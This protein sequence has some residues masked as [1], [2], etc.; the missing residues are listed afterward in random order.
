MRKQYP[1][2][3]SDEIQKSTQSSKKNKTEIS[4]KLKEIRL[5]MVLQTI[6]QLIASQKRKPLTGIWKYKFFTEDKVKFDPLKLP[7]TKQAKH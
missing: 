1:N 7:C 6:K 3:S 4:I 5:S 2:S